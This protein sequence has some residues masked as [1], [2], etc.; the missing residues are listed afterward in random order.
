MSLG[1]GSGASERGESIERAHCF[2]CTPAF[3]L[4]SARSFVRLFVFAFAVTR[5]HISRVS[6]EPEAAGSVLNTWLASASLRLVPRRRTAPRAVTHLDE[7]PFRA[8]SRTI[9]EPTRD[10]SILSLFLL[11]FFTYLYS[12]FFLSYFFFFLDLRFL[13][14]ES[15]WL[16]VFR[17]HR[18]YPTHALSTLSSF[19]RFS[20]DAFSQRQLVRVPRFSR[21]LVTR[22][23]A[24]G[25]AARR[26]AD[27]AARMD[28]SSGIC[29]SPIGESRGRRRARDSSPLSHLCRCGCTPGW[30]LS[31]RLREREASRSSSLP[32]ARE[33]ALISLDN[34]LAIF[35][36]RDRRNDFVVA[37]HSE[38]S[39]SSPTF[40]FRFVSSSVARSRGRHADRLARMCD[41][42]SELPRSS[43]LI[44]R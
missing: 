14:S 4:G 41:R 2:W 36:R 5:R 22:R 26:K 32:L 44:Q 11:D 1:E 30:S 37:A 43:S 18:T 6:R 27:E 8:C 33:T 19:G 35:S 13:F 20:S 42:G 29:H 39:L 12:H 40:L 31:S 7:S 28:L 17:K 34:G 23:I 38:S 21:I 10:G 9:L 25:L 16:A 3:W 24:K 15:S